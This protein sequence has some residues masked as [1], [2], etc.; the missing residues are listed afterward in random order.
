MYTEGPMP[1][2]LFPRMWASDLLTHGYDGALAKPLA[3]V[4][5]LTEEMEAC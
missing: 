1:Y 4:L 3:E 5:R 2:D